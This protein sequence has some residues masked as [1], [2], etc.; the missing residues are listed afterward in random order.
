[1]AEETTED[2]GG[3]VAAT[4]VGED[5]VAEST[6]IEVTEAEGTAT[7]TR[8]TPEPGGTAQATENHEAGG[9]PGE[10]SETG[11]M[12]GGTTAAM[13]G[14][15]TTAIRTPQVVAIAAGSPE[16]GCMEPWNMKGDHL[17]VTTREAAH[18]SDETPRQYE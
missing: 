14:A 15:P 7:G 17:S 8:T 12:E 1:M 2:P 18:R 6:A 16:D 11:R 10:R 5:M 3:T 4:T 9:T 13:A